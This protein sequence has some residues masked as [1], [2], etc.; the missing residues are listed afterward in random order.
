MPL[1]DVVAGLSLHTATPSTAPSSPLSQTTSIA[2]SSASVSVQQRFVRPS[3]KV[4]CEW[5][6]NPSGSCP[7]SFDCIPGTCLSAV[8]PFARL[9]RTG[10]GSRFCIGSM[11]ATTKHVDHQGK[12]R[13]LRSS[14]HTPPGFV[15]S[16]LARSFVFPLF[17]CGFWQL[18]Y[19]YIACLF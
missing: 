4:P 19:A 2:S 6:R 9:T 13:L 1:W 11:Y 16:Y 12:C 8:V 17:F 18:Q 15:P 7:D 14:V 5:E 10:I 3:R